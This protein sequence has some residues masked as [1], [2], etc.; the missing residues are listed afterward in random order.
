[1]DWG[2]GSTPVAYISGQAM[3]SCCGSTLWQLGATCS[4]AEFENV[5][6]VFA[7]LAIVCVGW[8]CAVA[9]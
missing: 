9:I 5:V 4:W 1:M 7:C 2:D 6:S 3:M 8:M